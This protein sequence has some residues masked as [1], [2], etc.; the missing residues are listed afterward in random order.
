ML[1]KQLGGNLNHNYQFPDIEIKTYLEIFKQ[2]LKEEEN[3]NI[4]IDN[5]CQPG[6]EQNETQE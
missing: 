2:M 6:D 3:S 4:A 5:D 1:Y